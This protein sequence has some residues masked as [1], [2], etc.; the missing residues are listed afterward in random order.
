[1]PKLLRGKIIVGDIVEAHNAFFERAIWRNI[2]VPRLRWED[3]Q[4]KQWR[5]SAAKAATCSIPRALDKAGDALGL[6]VQKDTDGHRVMLK[7]AK[8]RKPSKHNPA[9]Y[10]NKDED[11]DR[12]YSYCLDDVSSER[13]LSKALPNLPKEEQ[14]LWHLDQKINERGIRVDLPAVKAAM[15][16]AEEAKK[17]LD[18]MIDKRTGGQVKSASR[19]AAMLK[20]V[21]DRGVDTDTLNAERIRELIVDPEVPR[22]V[23][24]VLRLRQLASK[25]SV[26]KYKAVERSVAKDGRLH[27]LLMFHGASTGRWTGKLVQPQNFPRNRYEGDLEQYYRLLKTTSYEDFKLLYPNPLEP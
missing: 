9:I 13:C 18:Q 8:P 7:L 19:I 24:L 21:R 10:H 4:D 20:W 25:T 6:E 12:L 1:M 23:K 11:Y 15:S 27:D 2:M 26:S 16:H 5:C 3:I 14:Q 17:E 22:P